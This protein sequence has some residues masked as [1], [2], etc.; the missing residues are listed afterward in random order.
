MKAK[1]IFLW[2]RTKG[3]KSC[4]LCGAAIETKKIGAHNED[5]FCTKAHEAMK[6]KL[7]QTRIQWKLIVFPSCYE[8][9]IYVSKNGKQRKLNHF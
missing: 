5:Y 3:T 6:A 4:S 9:Y 8:N 1:M 7:M 2:N